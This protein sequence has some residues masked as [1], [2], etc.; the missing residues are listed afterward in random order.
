MIYLL[1]PTIAFLFDSVYSSSVVR[2]VT[3]EGGGGRHES[4]QLKTLFF[5]ISW[6]G[7]EVNCHYE[8]LNCLFIF[9]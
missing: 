9:I 3:G 4:P 1:Y 8:T 7:E 2:V 5:L 6:G